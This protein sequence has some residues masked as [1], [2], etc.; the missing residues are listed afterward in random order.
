ME[1]K[2]GEKVGTWIQW[3]EN[4]TVVKSTDYASM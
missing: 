1:Y 3:D 2:D 4:G